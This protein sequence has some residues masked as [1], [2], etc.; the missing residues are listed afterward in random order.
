M[1]RLLIAISM[2]LAGACIA[3]AEAQT[4]RYPDR[5][6]RFIVPFAPSGGADIVARV[7]A[8]RIGDTLG[9]QVVIDNRAGG[10]GT[11]GAEIA[12]RATPDG[13]TLIMGSASYAISPSLYKLPYDAIRDVTPVGMLATAPFVIVVNP[14]VPAKSVSELIAVAKAKPG[15]M[16]FGSSGIGSITHLATELF[17]MM[18]GVSMTHIPYKGNGPALTDL[19]GGQIHLIF[20]TSPVVGP[21]VQTGRLRALAVSGRERTAT[22]PAVP[23]VA[24]AGLRGYEVMTWYA[25]WGPRGLPAGIVSRWN[26]EINRVIQIPDVMERFAS[27]GLKPAPGSPQDFATMLKRDV[28]RWRTVVQKTN[29]KVL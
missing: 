9:Q 27:D 7:V 1:N 3:A 25:V 28:E 19:L 12:A 23:T 6:V 21:H 10:G 14:S 16:N 5:P 22:L 20:L 24:E 11:I 29:V 8:G 4:S 26:G 2:T 13:Y 17:D 18:A 15:A